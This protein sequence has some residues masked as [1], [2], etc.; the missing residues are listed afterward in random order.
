MKIGRYVID[1]DNMTTEELLVIEQ[2]IHKIRRRKEQGKNFIYQMNKL[3][4]EAK[5]NGFVFI[6]KD[7]GHILTTSDFAIHDEQ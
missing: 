3:I 1:T 7:F 2:E 5:E 4:T 6:D